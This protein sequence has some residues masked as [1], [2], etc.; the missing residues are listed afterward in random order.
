MLRG[1]IMESQVQ[2]SANSNLIEIEALILD[3]ARYNT[4]IVNPFDVAYSFGVSQGLG[5]L[6]GPPESVYPTSD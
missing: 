4:K 1:V 2:S 5:H 6:Y 3:H